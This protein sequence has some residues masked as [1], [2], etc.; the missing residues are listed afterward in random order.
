[1]LQ[2]AIALSRPALARL[3]VSSSNARAATLLLWYCVVKRCLQ[4][5]LTVIK[6]VTMT[7]ASS[8]DSKANFD[9]AN[10][11]DADWYVPVEQLVAHRSLCWRLEFCNPNMRQQ[12]SFH[13]CELQYLLLQLL[14]AE[15]VS[16]DSIQTL[17][18]Q[19]IICTLNPQLI[20]WKYLHNT[21][22]ESTVA[23]LDV[24]L[25]EWSTWKCILQSQRTKEGWDLHVAE[26]AITMERQYAENKHAIRAWQRRPLIMLS[27]SGRQTLD[28]QVSNSDMQL[29]ST[30][31]RGC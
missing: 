27:G 6:E 30:F 16:I 11:I 17:C 13:H 9:R 14:S 18:F 7:T 5:L 2:K 19:C 10:I 23:C 15:G 21:S 26:L 1:M 8:Q 24:V 3:P 25:E 12:I 31:S 20:L 4:V 29:M 22:N 28:V